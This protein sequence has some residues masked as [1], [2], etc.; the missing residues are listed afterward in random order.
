MTTP[1]NDH[2]EI[3]ALYCI[4]ISDG[5]EIIPADQVVR[6]LP[7]ETWT[8]SLIACGYSPSESSI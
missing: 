3:G 1:Q 6:D 2:F 7:G 8:Q 4:A 5:S